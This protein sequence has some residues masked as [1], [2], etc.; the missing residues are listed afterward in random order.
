MSGAD[1]RA[2]IL[3]RI[4][5]AGTGGDPALPPEPAAMRPGDPDLLAA[6]IEDYEA[7]VTR[8]GREAQIAAAAAAILSRHGAHRVAVPGGLPRSWLPEGVEAIVDGEGLAPRELASVDAAFTGSAL[9][10]AET[11]T[12]V[13]DAGPDQGRRALT[14]LPDLHLCVV[15]AAAVMA[16]VGDAIGALA[17]TA[18]PVTFVSG[19][20][21]TSDIELER[22]E[23]VHGPRRLEVLLVD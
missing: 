22:V 2:E 14:L 10:I 23:G 11:G 17:G 6:R 8:L 13:L 5:A 3:A 19:P 20:S 9:A 18:R 1:A 7:R 12:I 16:D 15:R 4:G 21:A